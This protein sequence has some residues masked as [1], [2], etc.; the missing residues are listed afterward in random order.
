MAAYSLHQPLTHLIHHV[1]HFDVRLR[2]VH[3]GA[4]HF[5][6]RGRVQ[7]VVRFEAGRTI[8][9][10]VHF[11]VGVR[12]PADVN[13]RRGDHAGL[14]RFQV[15]ARVEGPA[16]LRMVDFEEGRFVAVDVRFYDRLW[17]D[18]DRAHQGGFGGWL[19]LK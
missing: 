18:L 6:R 5:N 9:A 13:V 12:A 17:I 3:A 16:L 14:A 8:V 4:L 7:V 19:G 10:E 15:E 1:I 2:N 11:Q